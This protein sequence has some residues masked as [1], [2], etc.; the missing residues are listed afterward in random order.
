MEQNVILDINQTKIFS[1]SFG[2]AHWHIPRDP[3]ILSYCPHSFSFSFDQFEAV[4]L[5]IIVLKWNVSFGQIRL[6]LPGTIDRTSS[7]ESTNMS[8][9]H[10]ED[11]ET[12]D[13][14]PKERYDSFDGPGLEWIGRWCPLDDRTLPRSDL[15]DGGG[16]ILF[17]FTWIW[18]FDGDLF[19]DEALEV[20]REGI[21]LVEI[22]RELRDGIVEELGG[23]SDRL[24]LILPGL[25]DEFIGI[26]F[27]ESFNVTVRTI[28]GLFTLSRGIRLITGGGVGRESS[29]S[30]KTI[31][32]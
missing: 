19:R 8:C 13:R 32:I 29:S 23:C 7:L 3:V 5:V 9:V 21:E 27:D 20:L 16:S 6:F 24:L 4:H 17:G 18:P 14:W 31:T 28:F 15:W 11:P 22:G 1:K 30:L 12:V 25:K 26:V 2:G 10:L